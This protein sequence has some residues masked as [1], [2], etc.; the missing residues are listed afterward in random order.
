GEGGAR[1]EADAI[2]VV[3]MRDIA[4]MDGAVEEVGGGPA[5]ETGGAFADKEDGEVIVVAGAER[6]AGE[7][8]EEIVELAAALF[9]FGGAI[10]DEA[11]DGGGATGEGEDQAGGEG[12]DEQAG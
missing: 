2:D 5:A 7:S 12:G 6:H 8:V 3:G 11:F 1:G 9:E 10:G 4:K